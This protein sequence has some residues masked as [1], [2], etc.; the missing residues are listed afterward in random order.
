VVGQDPFTVIVGWR[1]CELARTR[2]VTPSNVKPI[3]FHPPL[4][5]F[6]HRYAP[7]V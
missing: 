2:N 7:I 4:R 1:L 6:S 3:A 5:N